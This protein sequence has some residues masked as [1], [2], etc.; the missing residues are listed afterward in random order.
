MSSHY[1]RI[2][3]AK[4]VVDTSPPHGASNR[5]QSHIR[6]C[7]P[8]KYGLGFA[9]IITSDTKHLPHAYT[10][11]A[12]TELRHTGSMTPHKQQY[13]FLE[14]EGGHCHGRTLA[15]KES[16]QPCRRVPDVMD[17]HAS[18][19]KLPDQAFKPRILKTDAQSRLHNLKVYYPPRRKSRSCDSGDLHEEEKQQHQPSEEEVMS[20]GTSARCSDVCDAQKHVSSK[21]SSHDSAYDGGV[22]SVTGSREPTPV[23]V[24]PVVLTRRLTAQ[25]KKKDAAY[26]KFVH[27]ITEDVLAQGIYSDQG[28]WRLFQRHVT[29]NEGQLNMDRMQVEVARLCD[30]LGIATTTWSDDGRHLLHVTEGRKTSCDNFLSEAKE[31]AQG[32]VKATVCMKKVRKIP[33]QT[34]SVSMSDET[35]G[36]SSADVLQECEKLKFIGSTGT[37]GCQI[38]EISLTNQSVSPNKMLVAQI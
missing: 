7:S 27:D 12:W 34:V 32:R 4:C 1:R 16:W 25:V 2:Y 13:Q 36:S 11:H 17:Q 24:C 10:K 23:A 30:Q 37:I 18:S 26:T 3:A 31:V 21:E 9:D 19:F 22:S 14:G 35:V 15:N 20:G 28:L 5:W 8:K 38:S 29:A 33:C 6:T